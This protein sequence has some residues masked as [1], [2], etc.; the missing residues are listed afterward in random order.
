MAK[1]VEHWTPAQQEA[2]K[3]DHPLAEPK[4]WVVLDDNT[5]ED[6]CDTEKDA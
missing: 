1:R 2:W 4:P 6:F 5:V 3:K